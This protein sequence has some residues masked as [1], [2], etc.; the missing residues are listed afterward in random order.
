[1]SGW[2]T[3][4]TAGVAEADGVDT[5]WNSYVKEKN[6]DGA[7]CAPG[8]RAHNRLFA[9]EKEGGLR[10]DLLKT[11]DIYYELSPCEVSLHNCDSSCQS[12]SGLIANVHGL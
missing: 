4:C 7:V 6:R 10:D 2:G 5:T 1:M 8:Y 12:M 11:V 3:V 9:D